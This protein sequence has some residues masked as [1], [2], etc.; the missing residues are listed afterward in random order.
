MTTS[1]CSALVI[2][3][4]WSISRLPVRN[5]AEASRIMRSPGNFAR[6][7]TRLSITRSVFL[8]LLSECSQMASAGAVT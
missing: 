1:A 7:S 2:K 4:S 8:E 3:R 5:P 6:P